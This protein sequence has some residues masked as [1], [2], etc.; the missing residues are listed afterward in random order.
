M[1]HTE[2]SCWQCPLCE[3]PLTLNQSQ[4]QCANRHCFDRAKEGYVNLLP[5]QHKNSKNPGDSKAMVAA[6]QQF[7]NQ[8]HYAP[9]VDAI[10]ALLRYH[11]VTT[12][13][14][15][16]FD[17]GCG[18]GYYSRTLSALFSAQQ[19]AVSIYGIDIAKAAVQKAAKQTVNG[20]FAVASTFHIPTQADVFD[21]AIQIFAPASPTEVHRILKPGGIWLCVDPN[22]YH[23]QELKQLVYDKPSLH[24]TDTA[25]PAGFSMLSTEELTFRIRLDTPEV[26]EQLLMMTPFYWTTS[27]T[28]VARLKAE[29]TQVT[30]SF[31]LKLLVKD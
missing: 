13:T 20:H 5:A 8:G 2:S 7:L 24:N 4:W 27:P 23:L 11:C 30:A 28:K 26:R 10:L 9:L 16:L 12:D 18:E 17:V 14:L 22:E 25:V 19:Q 31:Q 29:L 21:A 3:T 15:R 6:R 1:T